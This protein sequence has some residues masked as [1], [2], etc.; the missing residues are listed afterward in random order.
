MSQHFCSKEHFQTSDCSAGKE[1]WKKGLIRG[2]NSH[3]IKL[4]VKEI[5]PNICFLKKPISLC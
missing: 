1:K 2:R 5:K 4:E 3:I